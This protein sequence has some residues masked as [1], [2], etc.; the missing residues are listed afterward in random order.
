MWAPRGAPGDQIAEAAGTAARKRGTGGDP[1]DPRPQ[2]RPTCRPRPEARPELARG[3]GAGVLLLRAHPGPECAE[4]V[5][6]EPRDGLHRD[7]LGAG[8]G[9]LTDVGAATEALAVLLGDHVDHPVVALGLA[10]GEQ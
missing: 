2:W 8:R 3:E 7:A 9:A 10:L 6:V 1:K 4:Q 5:V